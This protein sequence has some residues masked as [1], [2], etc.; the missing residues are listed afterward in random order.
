MSVASRKSIR[1]QASRRSIGSHAQQN[2]IQLKLDQMRSDRLRET[3]MSTTLLDPQSNRKYAAI[4]KKI[5]RGPLNCDINEVRSMS[6]TILTKINQMLKDQND[7]KFLMR[8][9]LPRLPPAH[10]PLIVRTS[11]GKNAFVAENDAHSKESNFGYSRNK[12]GGF[13]NH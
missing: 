11:G 4:A 2:S 12:F 10:H 5:Y 6:N 13:Y 7:D 3:G 1:S 9:S 8:V